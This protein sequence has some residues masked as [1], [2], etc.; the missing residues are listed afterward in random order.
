MKCDGSYEEA[1]I[2]T[3]LMPAVVKCVGTHPVDEPSEEIRLMLV[4]LVH[5]AVK[6]SG[7]AMAPYMT[8]L[9]AVITTSLAGSR[10]RKTRAR[11]PSYTFE[12]D[13]V[14]NTSF[15]KKK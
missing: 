3:S 1:P 7:A 6:K 2:L 9:A 15:K 10:T 11:I 5:V 14:C 8:E 13:Q 12:P 4:E